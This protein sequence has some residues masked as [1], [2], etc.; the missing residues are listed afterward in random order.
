MAGEDPPI[1]GK[2]ILFRP[3]TFDR[4]DA[5]AKR[6]E[7]LIRTRIP[8]RGTGRSPNL[9]PGAWGLLAS[10]GT[11]TGA[12][13]LT[14]GS[15]SVKLCDRTGSVYPANETVAVANAGGSISGPALLPL[16]WTA[17][18]WT[19]CGC[20]VA[21]SPCVFCDMPNEDLVLSWNNTVSGSG[22]TPMIYDSGTS[23][24]STGCLAVGDGHIKFI[25][26]CMDGFYE[27]GHFDAGCTL[28]AGI[29]CNTDNSNPPSGTFGVASIVCSPLHMHFITTGPW[30]EDLQFLG[31]TDFFIDGP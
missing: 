12:S 28:P 2:P 15:G 3:E 16:E 4:H 31:Y 22:S 25:F 18:E 11:I 9:A 27:L 1:G 10:G 21:T 26:G 29:G 13:G 17:G 6:V 14:L 7:G 20:T 24:W 19:V 8:R 23:K 30:C 5:A